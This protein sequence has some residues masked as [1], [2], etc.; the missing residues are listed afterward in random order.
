MYPEAGVG[1]VMLLE[2]VAKGPGGA[3]CSW[4]ALRIATG[5]RT[6]CRPQRPSRADG[7]PAI[8]PGRPHGASG[9]ITTVVQP[10]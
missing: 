9:K 8:R 1:G 4:P 5:P 2:A 6:T 7:G 3:W 10:G